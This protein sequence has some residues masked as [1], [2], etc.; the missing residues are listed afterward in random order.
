LRPEPIWP[1][2]TQTKPRCAAGTRGLLTGAEEH[3]VT[4][5]I[6]LRLAERLEM[7]RVQV[8]MTRD[9]ADVSISNVERALLA[10]EA[11]ADLSVRLHCDGVRRG[12]RPLGLF[13]RGCLTLVPGGAH[14]SDPLQR[15]SRRV[16]EPLQAALVSATGFHD[17][18]MVERDDLSGFNWSPIPA[19]LL[20]LGYLTNPWEERRLLDPMVQ[21]RIA[22]SL[23]TVLGSTPPSRPDQPRSLR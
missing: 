7:R 13:W 8:T 15:A 11:G 5:D 3:E 4:L 9:R 20:E 1:G 14:V 16:A 12:L 23:S 17:R 18:G 19:V 6:A 21:E 22:E 10:G 2:S